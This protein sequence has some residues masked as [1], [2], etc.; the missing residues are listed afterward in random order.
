LVN[1][2]CEGGEL[3]E[4]VK[5]VDMGPS[6]R[7]KRWRPFRKRGSPRRSYG[8]DHVHDDIPKPKICNCVQPTPSSLSSPTNLLLPGYLCHWAT[9]LTTICCWV[10]LSAMSPGANS[11]GESSPHHSMVWSCHI[12]SFH[13]RSRQMLGNNEFI[14]LYC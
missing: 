2:I 8:T 13:V 10:L 5:Q 14:L 3:A 11:Q 7:H 1:R 12:M 6:W 9:C 4:K